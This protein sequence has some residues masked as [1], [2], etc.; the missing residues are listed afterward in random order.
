[1]RWCGAVGVDVDEVPVD[2][3][4]GDPEGVGDLLHGVLLGVVHRPGL[5]VGALTLPAARGWLSPLTCLLGLVLLALSRHLVE[6]QADATSLHLVDVEHATAS[7][8]WLQ[9]D[10]HRRGRGTVTRRL[11]M[12]NDLARGLLSTHPTRRGDSALRRANAA[13]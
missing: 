4:P 11:I 10:Q 2:R 9:Q 8:A 1:M 5:L 6:L 3:R 12:L 7:L 13:S